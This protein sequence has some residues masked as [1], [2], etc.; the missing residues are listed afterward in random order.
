MKRVAFLVLCALTGLC[1][2]SA[3]DSWVNDPPATLSAT[4]A[5]PELPKTQFVEVPISLAGLAEEMLTAAP[6]VALHE[7]DLF[8]FYPKCAPPGLAYLVRAVFEHGSN[9]AFH[10]MQLGHTLWVLHYALGP[11][12]ARHRSALVVCTDTPPVAI[13]VSAGGAM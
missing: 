9:G 10:V 5:M 6:S 11:A 1:F 4:H 12:S 2:A 7:H 8:D 3:D 13:Y